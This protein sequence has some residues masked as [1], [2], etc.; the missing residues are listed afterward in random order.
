MD[1]IKLV[2]EAVGIFAVSMLLLLVLYILT[3]RHVATGVGWVNY[4]GPVFILVGCFY[5]ALGVFMC[6]YR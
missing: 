4:Q 3:H 6:Y 5:A 2:F 1:T